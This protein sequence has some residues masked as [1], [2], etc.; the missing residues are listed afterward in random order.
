MCFSLAD[1][2]NFVLLS[3]LKLT[4]KPPVDILGSI[5]YIPQFPLASLPFS[6]PFQWGEVLNGIHQDIVQF[7]FLGVESKQE[8]YKWGSMLSSFLSFLYNIDKW[9]L[10]FEFGFG[11]EIEQTFQ[12][13]VLRP[14]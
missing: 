9:D 7:A 13:R 6:T 4:R 11:V 14:L 8:G 3:N 2:H 12:F 5:F 1:L 10:R